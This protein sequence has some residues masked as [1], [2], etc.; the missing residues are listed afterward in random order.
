MNT[1]RKFCMLLASMLLVSLAMGAEA[2]ASAPS[3]AATRFSMTISPTRLDIGQGQAGSIQR[4]E[5]INGGRSP[6]KVTI[7]KLP[8]TGSVNGTM[9]FASDPSYSAASWV[10]LSASQ[11]TV[12]PGA[13]EVI[14]ARVSIPQHTEPGDHQLALE[15]LVPAGVTKGNIKIN[16]GIAIPVYITVPGPVSDTTALTQ[17]SAPS[18]SLGGPVTITAKVREGG[19]GHRDFRGPDSLTLKGSS[20]G[21]VFPDFTVPRDSS[22][23]ISTT[24]KPPFFCL[25]SV[26]V[27]IPG[28]HGKSGTATVQM[29]VI[30]LIPIAIALGCLLLLAITTRF[31]RY[32]YRGSVLRAAAQLRPVADG[33]RT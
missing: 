25:C 1:M 14:T 9:D 4:I 12:A 21:V 26:T 31:V 11:F 24:W 15:F 33:L 5:V 18:L 28:A 29:I 32:R 30:P 10:T 8:F 17:L 2:Y 16:R 13:T 22:R 3:H 19:T 23:I 27:S 20:S 6:F 7:N